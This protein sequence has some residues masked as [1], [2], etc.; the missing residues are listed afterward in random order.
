M[1]STTAAIEYQRGVPP[2]APPR[3]SSNQRSQGLTDRS[4]RSDQ[5]EVRQSNA[6]D[7]T[8]GGGPQD[9]V[10][11]N[12]N[13]GGR[14]TNGVEREMGGDDVA[15]AAS[16]ASRSR[17]RAQQSP[18]ATQPQRSSSS[19]EARSAQPS[20]SAQSRSQVK[21]G[22]PLS[23]PNGLSREGSEILNRVVISK[24]EV[25]LDRER[26]R[27]RMAEAQ[28]QSATSDPKV[29]PG[30]NVVDGEGADHAGRGGSRSRHDATGASSKREKH[31]RFGEY[32]LGNTLGEGE[33]GKVKMGWKQE[34][35]VQVSQV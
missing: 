21:N 22:A 7:T 9:R 4:R 11:T 12:R 25:D 29:A 14:H 10:D 30:L 3:T 16:A 28:P 31:T 34:G 32:F 13:T 33:F 26:E 1:H 15:A 5:V 20:S 23:T 27:E 6:P 17:R 18:Q 35:G 19:R 24:P 8:S 2:V